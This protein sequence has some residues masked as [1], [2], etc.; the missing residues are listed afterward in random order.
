MPGPHDSPA[1]PPVARR[2]FI[3][4]ELPDEI[5]QALARLDHGVEGVR[6]VREELLHVTLAFLG[7]VDAGR[8]AR[9][10][11]SLLAVHV[12]AFT[13]RVVGVG[14]FGGSRPRV[15]WAGLADGHPHLLRLHAQV[16]EAVQ[17]AGLDPDPAPFHP[18]VTIGRTRAATRRALQPFLERYRDAEFGAWTVSS[19]ALFSSVL[20]A[21]GPAVHGG[22]AAGVLTQAGVM[23]GGADEGHQKRRFRECC[24]CRAAPGHADGSP[25]PRPGA[26]QAG[27]HLCAVLSVRREG[28]RRDSPLRGGFL[29][30]V[31]PAAHGRVRGDPPASRRRV[32]LVHPPLDAYDLL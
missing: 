31:S 12:P 30:R 4:L 5:R 29:I 24:L 16:T 10:R 14:A 6:W 17:R 26:P 1:A 25:L 18:H 2:L 9:L 32:P 20:S 19:V 23:P 3:G 7:D 8:E 21:R 22:V 11:A 13:L 28:A 27:I 15:V